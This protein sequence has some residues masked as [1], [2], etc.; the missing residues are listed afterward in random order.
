MRQNTD[1][2]DTSRAINARGGWFYVS[3]NS[4]SAFV[5]VQGKDAQHVA[6]RAAKG[7]HT[8]DDVKPMT[9]E[10]WAYVQQTFALPTPKTEG[11]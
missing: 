10:L 5:A 9:R 11:R 4:G 7:G 2:T 3:L 1:V 8:V 6:R